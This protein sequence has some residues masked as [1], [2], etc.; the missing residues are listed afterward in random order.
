MIQMT[1]LS[2]RQLE[3]LRGKVA[4]L[5][6][7]EARQ[8]EEG[9]NRGRRESELRS[10]WQAKACPTKAMGDEDGERNTRRGLSDVFVG[11]GAADGGPWG[12]DRD[13]GGCNCT[14]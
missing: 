10:D 3:C 9:M 1:L 6:A 8:E 11:I 4:K 5:A 13:A 12:Y 7:S 14:G 2:L